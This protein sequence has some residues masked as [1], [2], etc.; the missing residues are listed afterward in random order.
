MDPFQDKDGDG[1]VRGRSGAG[2]LETLG[3][4]LGISGDKNDFVPDGFLP[5]IDPAL[6]RQ[7]IQRF[8]T[9]Q[10]RDSQMV[11]E[12]N[13]WDAIEAFRHIFGLEVL[14]GP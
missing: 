3:P 14:T 5:P 9:L 4:G 1:R 10:G 6:G 8:L 13:K 11:S 7:F 2:L 12:W